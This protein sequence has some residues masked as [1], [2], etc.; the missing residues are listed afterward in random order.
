MTLLPFY[1][2]LWDYSPKPGSY[3]LLLAYWL[4]G[5]VFH[6]GISIQAYAR[7]WPMSPVIPEHPHLLPHCPPHSEY[8]L[9]TLMS[10]LFF[11]LLVHLLRENVIFFSWDG[12]FH[13]L[14]WSPVYLFP[15]SDISF[16]LYG[17]VFIRFLLCF[18]SFS[19]F[20]PPPS[21]SPFCFFFLEVW[22]CYI[23]L[24]GFKH[25]RIL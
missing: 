10:L 18:S 7:M 20:P 12:L 8:F 6:W 13:W 22:S 9:F 11:P 21:L 25:T 3:L 23:A 2:Q 5:Q 1:P 4:L 15:A 24:A 14:W 17:F 16:I 19:S